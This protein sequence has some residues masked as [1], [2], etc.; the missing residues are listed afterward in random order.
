VG[1]EKKRGEMVKICMDIEEICEGKEWRKE[2]E[3][4]GVE[5]VYGLWLHT[6]LMV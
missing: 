6:L 2:R 5:A 1:G 4:K 3:G